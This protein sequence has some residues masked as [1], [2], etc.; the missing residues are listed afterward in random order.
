MHATQRKPVLLLGLVTATVMVFVVL[1]FVFDRTGEQAS[2]AGSARSHEPTRTMPEGLPG[3]AGETYTSDLDGMVERGVIRA[4]VVPSLTDF[5][6]LQ[7]RI[8]GIQAELL[9]NL[10]KHI[11]KSAD[12]DGLDVRIVYVPVTFSELIPALLDG[13]GDIA[14][15]I[16]TRTP[17]REAMVDFAG[18]M[19]FP[20]NEV[21]VVGEDVE[22]IETIDDLAGRRIHVLQDSSYAE[23]LEALNQD[24]LT[25]KLERIDIVEM[26]PHLTTEDILELLN[27]GLVEITIADDYK[28]TLWAEVLPDIIVREDIV[29]RENTSAGWAVR[30]DNPEL[31][32][33]IRKA[34]RKVREGTLL[35][36]IFIERYFGST[37][38][39]DNPLAK[40][41]RR[42]FR[43]YADLF[44][45]YGKRYDFDW[46]ALVAQA[47]QE[48]G[49]DHS[50]ESPAGAVGIM[51]LL[52][53]TAADP[54][55]GIEDISSVESNI[56][57]GAKYMS[58]LQDRYFADEELADIDRLAFTWAAYNAGPRKVRLMRQH[59]ARA[60]LDPDQWFGHVEYA[61]LDIIGQETVRYVANIYKY[62]IAYRL[63]QDLE[64]ARESARTSLE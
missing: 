37:Q 58:F 47:Y 32:A 24:F 25:R 57:A 2:P 40:E 19:N 7:G 51:Q 50:A 62:Y 6:S 18:G 48:S 43:R 21:V 30:K 16:L 12:R 8:L 61:A 59:A 17:E 36:N 13:R 14:A 26:D 45:K 53:S 49:L 10:E 28:A 11:N 5:F 23:H 42:Q 33:A 52:P 20:I 15:A 31:A 60:G 35:G 41:D 55:V 39:I 44:R 29:L 34:S 64:A 38:W 4:L 56:H 3:V 54:N 46:I 27:A 9:K 22:D 63:S 1:A